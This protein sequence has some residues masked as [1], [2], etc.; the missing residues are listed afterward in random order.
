MLF[1]AL[2]AHLALAPVVFGAQPEGG[3]ESTPS[4]AGKLD[5]RL[6]SILSR[7]REPNGK[8]VPD[9]ELADEL[10]ALLQLI[11]G[12][13]SEFVHCHQRHAPQLKV[14]KDLLT[15]ETVACPF[16]GFAELH[17]DMGFSSDRIRWYRSAIDLLSSES[18]PFCGPQVSLFQEELGQFLRA[19]TDSRRVNCE[20]Q[21]F[22]GP[23]MELKDA[24][25]ERHFWEH[26]AEPM[27]ATVAALQRSEAMSQF[28]GEVCRKYEQVVR[29][30]YKLCKIMI[31]SLG[32]ILKRLEGE[33]RH[34]IYQQLRPW[35]KGGL[36]PLYDEGM[37]WAM[38]TRTKSFQM[39]FQKRLVE[40]QARVQVKVYRR[41]LAFQLAFLEL[42]HYGTETPEFGEGFGQGPPPLL[43]WGNSAIEKIEKAIANQSFGTLGPLNPLDDQARNL[44]GWTRSLC[45]RLGPGAAEHAKV[46]WEN[47]RNWL[48]NMESDLVQLVEMMAIKDEFLE[49]YLLGNL[50]HRLCP[51]AVNVE[52]ALRILRETEQQEGG[53]A[54]GLGHVSEMLMLELERA[55][56]RRKRSGVKNTQ[57]PVCALG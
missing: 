8:L 18:N 33:D 47:S 57:S 9:S 54:D 12:D 51:I 3:F 49:L 52:R 28:E 35:L 11:S 20:I 27:D 37:P 40:L 34:L 36:S 22:W 30:M 24:Q 39:D 56:K 14:L 29:S 31:S 2:L 17:R 10:E 16:P 5:S 4:L 45:L 50:A 55:C 38:A 19:F 7:P 21:I 6:E 25:F 44:E 43:G 46:S 1:G 32:S 42:D 53:V 41:I 15:F 23:I 26:P 48:I 13:L